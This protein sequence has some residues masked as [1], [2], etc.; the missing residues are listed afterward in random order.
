MVRCKVDFHERAGVPGVVTV[1]VR[2]A[3][4]AALVATG[5]DDH[6]A[7]DDQNESYVN[8]WS[9]V[10]S[11]EGGDPETDIGTLM[12]NGELDTY[13]VDKY[14]AEDCSPPVAIVVEV[15]IAAF[16]ECTEG[17][18]GYLTGDGCGEGRGGGTRAAIGGCAASLTGNVDETISRCLPLSARC[19]WFVGR[20]VLGVTGVSGA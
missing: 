6:M 19:G 15:N 17:A 3:G 18:K 7:W 16:G 14:L 9:F 11:P 12:G 1:L 13:V 4:I 20:G 2:L 5:W 8:G 10:P